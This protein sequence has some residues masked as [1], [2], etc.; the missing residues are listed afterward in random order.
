M[1]DGRKEA[2]VVVF[3]RGWGFP[4]NAQATLSSGRFTAESVFGRSDSGGC[5][6]VPPSSSASREKASTPLAHTSSGSL[7]NEPGHRRLLAILPPVRGSSARKIRRPVLLLLAFVLAGLFAVF[8]LCELGFRLVERIQ[9]ARAGELW[10]L[11]DPDLGWIPNPSYGDHNALGLHDRPTSEKNGRTRILF[12]GDSVLYYGDS[13]DDTIVG[14]LRIDLER[15]IGPQAVDVVN[16]GIKGYTNWQEL[17]FLKLRGLDL[18]PDLVGVGF[19]LNDCHQRL[20]QFRVEDG[21]I[22]G[23]SYE[24]TEEAVG[25]ESGPKRILRQ[26]RFLVWLRHR[27]AGLEPPAAGEFTFDH[28]PDFRSAWLDEPWISIESQ[29]REMIDL[30]QQKGFRVFL[31]AFPFGDQYRPDYLERDRDHVLKPQ[32]KLAEICARLKIPFLDLYPL[33]DP[34]ADLD[35]DRIHLTAPGREKS[36]SRIAA[37]L[38]ENELL[39]RR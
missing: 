4:H 26:S 34:N 20:H 39:P 21:R 36:A 25:H 29:L 32:R 18:D 1:N 37:F 12:L 30:G 16:A 38:Q 6:I 11:H 23:P 9:L 28:R 31:V 8:L 7:A 2:L 35:E 13:V 22:V 27:F 3:P 17:Q 15:A 19:V 24:F 10:A 33:L 5:V 14:H